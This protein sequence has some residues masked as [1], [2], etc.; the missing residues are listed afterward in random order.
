MK[1][2]N[3]F[4][5]IPFPRNRLL[6]VD[7]GKLGLKKHTVHG[8]VEFD[9]TEARKSLKQ[10]RAQ[11][12]EAIS[13]SAFFLACLGKALEQ[14]KAM[15]AYRKGFRKM[16]I[17]DAVDVN[18][19]FEVEVDGQK[20][21]RPHILRG[22]NQ[23]SAP[24]IHQ[25]IRDFQSQH[26]Q[27]Q[28]AK[29]IES[30]VRLPGFIRRIIL[31]LFLGNPYFIKEYYGTVL[32]TSIGMFGAGAG[33]GIPVPNHSLQITLGGVVE[34]AAVVNSQIEIH[35]FMSVT[36]SFDHDVIDG[37]PAARFIHQLKKL[38]ERGYKPNEES[39]SDE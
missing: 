18:M 21:I 1:T 6:M 33:W 16:V 3:T 17:F 22:V 12:G 29:F 25:D 7:G 19:L 4:Q 11:T 32:V 36:V 8:L 34:K 10:Y 27:S 2:Q 9:I 5:T 26:H 28:E 14:N 24:A 31:R 20:T 35:K 39:Y 30:F 15:Q 23:K 37:A 13:F 38:I